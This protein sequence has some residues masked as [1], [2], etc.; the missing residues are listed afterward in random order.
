MS[1]GH[2]DPMTMR[3]IIREAFPHSAAKIIARELNL[4]HRQ[5]RRIA[6]GKVPRR[7]T[8]ALI[9]LCDRYL[10]WRKQA[11]DRAENL[12]REERNAEMV[13]RAQA[14]RRQASIPDGQAPS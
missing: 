3:A 4:S 8:A 11:I 14:R 5:G 10:A 6:A 2:G 12:S 9:D 7:T 1:R 13:A